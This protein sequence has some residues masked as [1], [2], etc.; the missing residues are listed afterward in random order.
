MGHARRKTDFGER[1]EDAVK[2]EIFEETGLKIKPK[3]ILAV[4]NEIFREKEKN[5]HIGIAFY[6]YLKLYFKNQ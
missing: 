1:I 2:R 6:F 4:L 3:R 5:N